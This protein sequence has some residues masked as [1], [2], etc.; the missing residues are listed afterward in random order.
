MTSAY[1]TMGLFHVLADEG[2]DVLGRLREVWTGGD[3]A[4]PAAIQRVLE[5]C[6]DTVL[7]HSYGPTEVTFASHQQRFPAGPER[8]FD[9][10]YLG[11][12]LDNTRGYVLDERLRPVPP[13]VAGE[14]Y[15]AGA[16][17]RPR[18]PRPP[19]ADRAALRGRPVGTRRRADVPHRRP[20]RLDAPTGSWVPRPDRRAG[21]AARLPDRAG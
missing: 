9:G 6:P 3:A 20:G 1:F 14:L 17:A 13:G 10:V 5:H 19:G 12:P 18:L 8:V 7:V 4:S 15:L 16:Q 21:Q 2:L 11:R